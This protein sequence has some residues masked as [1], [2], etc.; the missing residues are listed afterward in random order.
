M[1]RTKLIYGV[2]INDVGYCVRNSKCSVDSNGK[3]RFEVVWLCPY[4][5][6]WKSMITRCYSTKYHE[7]RPSYASCTVCED[8]LYFSKFKAWMETQDWEGKELDKDFVVPG[9]TIYS[10]ATCL[11]IPK[12]L[13][14]FF[15]KGRSENSI[16]RGISFSEKAGKYVARC[17]NG[18][19]KLMSLG[20]YSDLDDAK[21]VWKEAKLDILLKILQE[22]NV[23]DLIKQ[24]A[25]N[26]F[27][28]EITKE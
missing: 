25:I 9:N 21:Q 28:I 12:R 24:A 23:E 15:S 1:S 14:V 17:C 16:S 5:D 6:K 8:W 11:F 7:K 18:E 26:K 4:Y 20:Y 2:G 3:R 27:N 22:D 19:G 10:P 13:N